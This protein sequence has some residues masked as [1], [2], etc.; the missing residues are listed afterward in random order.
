[1]RI[2]ESDF[3]GTLQGRSI[4]GHLSESILPLEDGDRPKN[5]D[6]FLRTLF[7]DLKSGRYFP[8]L[9]RGYIVYDK[10]NRV[11]RI[12]PVF[13]YRDSCV[14]YLCIRQIED[15]IAGNRVVGT[16]GGWRLGNVI[17]DREDAES[18]DTVDPAFEFD[19][20]YEPEVST[21]MDGYILLGSFDPRKWQ[22]HYKDFQKRA[23]EWSRRDD[24][25]YFIEFDIANFYDSVNLDILER[26]I[27]SVPS[28]V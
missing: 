23:F 13:T 25:S 8:S 26:K 14:Y 10:Y 6:E 24:L 2:T 19:W 20:E 12:V 22:R 5:K 16:Y 11:A 27:V 4:Y 3:F 1:M 21:E 9:P 28:S 15:A 17:R 7:S 18:P